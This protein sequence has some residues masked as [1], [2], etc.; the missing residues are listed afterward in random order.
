MLR[1]ISF[2][3]AFLLL[4]TSFMAQGV[5]AQKGA[6]K[7]P[8]NLTL[9]IELKALYEKLLLASKDKDQQ[10]LDKILTANY[11]Q[12]T[13]DGRVRT[14]EIRIKETMQTDVKV[15]ILNLE[16]FNLFLYGNAAIARCRVRDKGINAGEA[17]DLTYLSTATFV[18]EKGQWKIAATHLSVLR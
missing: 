18:M 15:E 6:S 5:Y 13:A 14:K 8:K 4:L 17:F 9:Q 10:T 12:V 3:T 11:S 2:F 7:D 1:L 16:E